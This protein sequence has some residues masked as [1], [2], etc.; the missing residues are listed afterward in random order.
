MGCVTILGLRPS[1]D[2]SAVAKWDGPAFGAFFGCVTRCL[3]PRFLLPR[4]TKVEIYATHVTIFSLYFFFF[5]HAKNLGIWEA[6]KD[7]SDALGQPS[8]GVQMWPPKD[9]NPELGRSHKV[10]WG[11]ESADC[12]LGSDGTYDGRCSCKVSCLFVFI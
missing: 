12:A 8:P 3:R 6:A 1:K 10:F 7:G 5:G 2:S 9:A 11:Q 4:P